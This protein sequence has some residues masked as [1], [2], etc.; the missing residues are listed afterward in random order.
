MFL[1]GDLTDAIRF[2]L[3]QLVYLYTLVVIGAVVVSWV[4]A[5]PWNPIVRFLRA[6]TDPV[7]RRIRRWLPFAVIGGF[8]LSPL[9]LLIGLNVAHRFV[10]RLLLRMSMGF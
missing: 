7:F 8:D 4:E 10:D 1:I 3:G 6:A 2:V 9:I 5:N